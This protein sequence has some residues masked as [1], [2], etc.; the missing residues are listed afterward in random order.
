MPNRPEMKIMNS[1]WNKAVLL[2]LTSL[3]MLVVSCGSKTIE[4]PRIASNPSNTT[5]ITPAAQNGNVASLT[6]L[7]KFEQ[8]NG[9]EAF[10]LK[11][12]ENGA[13][14]VDGNSKE[15]ARLTVE[16]NQKVKIKDAADK[17]LGYVVS[18][19]GYWKIE[20][21]NQTQEL[22]ILRRQ[23][24]GDYKL[25]DGANKQIY[26][27][28]VRDYGFEIETPQKK[29]FYKV[30]VK[31]GKISLRNASEQTIFSTKSK[32]LPIAVAC[33]GFDV[34]SREQQAALAYAVNLSGGR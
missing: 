25:E 1:T 6:D 22:Y 32:F 16:E 10:A 4:K 9:A 12:K 27:I 34:L 13:K 31:E 8:D 3:S 24:D 28:K 33:F 20:N 5:E 21:A 14:F 26:R 18:K 11:P 29:S 30:K 2:I 17:V 19:P 15:L 7:V 23:D